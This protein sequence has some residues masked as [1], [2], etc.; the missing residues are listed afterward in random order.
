MRCKITANCARP[1]IIEGERVESEVPLMSPFSVHQLMAVTAQS[2]TLAASEKV[3]S[4][5]VVSGEAK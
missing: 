1:A 4:V 2:E 3:S 5:A